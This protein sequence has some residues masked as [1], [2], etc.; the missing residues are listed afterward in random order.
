MVDKE[1]IKERKR[2]YGDNFTAIAKLWT[3]Y[4][5]KKLG[6]VGRFKVTRKDVAKMMKFMKEARIDVIMEK[7]K[8][9]TRDEE[10]LLKTALQDSLNDRDNYE[11][12]AEHFEE[13]ERLWDERQ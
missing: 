12:I 7:L 8:D 9:C 2:I 6:T 3:D 5:S 1:L 4:L 11:W 10:V 13:Y